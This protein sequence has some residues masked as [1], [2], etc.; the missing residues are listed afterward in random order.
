MKS[1]WLVILAVILVVGSFWGCARQ[2]PSQPTN[3][4]PAVVDYKDL[5][6]SFTDF[7][8]R[9][10]EEIAIIKAEHTGR[11]VQSIPEFSLANFEVTKEESFKIYILS[12]ETASLVLKVEASGHVFEA[13]CSGTPRVFGIEG[14]TMTV[15][16]AFQLA[17]LR[18]L[19]GYDEGADLLE[20]LTVENR[21]ETTEIVGGMMHTRHTNDNQSFIS[22]LVVPE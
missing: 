19:H 3:G 12:N 1:I 14:D 9:F 18:I 17:T 8:D 20:R 10:N 5:G 22:L 4:Q 21:M 2:K 11:A 13:Y 7:F 15:T 16:E 6:I